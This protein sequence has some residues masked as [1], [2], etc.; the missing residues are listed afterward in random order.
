MT[1][2]NIYK[3]LEDL[4]GRQCIKQNE[5]MKNHTTFHIGGPAGI[6]ITP[7]GAESF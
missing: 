1:S 4:V 6:F 2:N 3:E 7:S 5:P